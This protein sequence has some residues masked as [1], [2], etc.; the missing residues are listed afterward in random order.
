MA[1]SPSEI[2]H[3]RPPGM[4]DAAEGISA[5]VRSWMEDHPVVDS[6]ETAKEA[7]LQIDRAK[8]CLLD[9]EAER[10]RKVKPLNAQVREIN[11]SYKPAKT[12]LGAIV[13]EINRRITDFLAKEEAKRIKIAQEARKKAE[14]AE[15]LA[16][17][18]EQRERDAI[19]DAKVGAIVD[20]ASQ[21]AEADA[22]FAEYQRSARQADVAERDSRVKIG[23]G[24]TRALSLRNK[25]TLVITNAISA[26]NT[27]CKLG[28]PSD[29][30]A[31][32]LK[33]ARAY[34]SVYGELPPGIESKIERSV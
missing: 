5:A 7:K 33:S 23:G 9:M 8:L 29:L 26:I 4:I 2:G 11:D 28:I 14:E 6:G 19:D 27:I 22:A 1:A 31:A 16:R 12:I 25:E 34:R 15:R 20:V 18:A 32:I 30:E 13:L 21:S 24:F 17:E 10:E 3:N